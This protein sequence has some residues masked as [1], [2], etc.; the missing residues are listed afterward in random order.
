[1]APRCFLK[2]PLSLRLLPFLSV[3]LS[4]H[5][6]C[7]LILSALPI[8]PLFRDH[9]LRKSARFTLS[10]RNHPLSNKQSFSTLV[11]FIS[12]LLLPPLSLLSL[13]PRL[14]LILHH[15]SFI[16]SDVGQ[17]HSVSPIMYQTMLCFRSVLTTGLSS[18]SNASP[19]QN[20]CESNALWCK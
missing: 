19:M 20:S 3:S 8:F 17:W 12:L 7:P 5:I 6:F 16:C 13:L 18:P 15:S 9:T 14:S 10:D 4:F 11:L 1:M 2:Q